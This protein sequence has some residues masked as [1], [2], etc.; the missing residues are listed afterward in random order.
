MGDVTRAD[1]NG[2]PAQKNLHRKEYVP[3]T[4]TSWMYEAVLQSPLNDACPN[5]SMASSSNQRHAD[6]SHKITRISKKPLVKTWS[7][8]NPS[9]ANSI[10]ISRSNVQLMYTV[11]EPIE[12]ETIVR[13]IEPKPN[14]Q[15]N[16]SH[17]PHSHFILSKPKI[18]KPKPRTSAQSF[19]TPQTQSISLK[20]QHSFIESY[21]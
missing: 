12:N 4:N 13:P 16:S 21:T 6:V 9:C 15:P 2:P 18:S 14:E 10:D 19:F 17:L 11:K 8:P 1:N 3:T 20:S 7:F 5:L